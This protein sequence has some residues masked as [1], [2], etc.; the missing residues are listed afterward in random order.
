MQSINKDETFKRYYSD[1]RKDLFNLI[2]RD[3]K[4]VLDVGCGTGELGYL[5][6][7]RG[8]EYVAG[9]ELKRE[10]AELARTKLDEVVE[11]D[12]EK[13]ELHFGEGYF[14]CIVFGDILEHL[15]DPWNA[16]M[17]MK[18]FLSDEGC[19]VCSIP[20]IRHYGVIARLMLDRWQYQQ[21]G[22]LDKSHLRFFTLGSIRTMIDEAG[23]TI[24]QLR[25]QILG[26]KS[27]RILNIILFNKLKD[28][29]TYHYLIVLKKKTG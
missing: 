9:V 6:K 19:M 5:L 3:S 21:E 4:R 14:D 8:I 2:P 10:V 17:R 16:L 11:A 23:Y 26:R 29:L 12:I 20:N 28:F 24:I 18:R 15:I 22:L 1:T 7:Q 27:M 13:I 25:R